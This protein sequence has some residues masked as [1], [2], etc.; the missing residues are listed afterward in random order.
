ML[1]QNRLSDAAAAIR[2]EHL[3][4]GIPQ[5]RRLFDERRGSRGR[6][7]RRGSRAGRARL[8][9]RCGAEVAT[10]APGSAE[11]RAGAVAGLGEAEIFVGT[12]A[13]CFAM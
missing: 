6:L 1:W 7:V 5:R 13:G 3:E 4:I 11:S 10:V 9:R 12:G 2:Q 8:R